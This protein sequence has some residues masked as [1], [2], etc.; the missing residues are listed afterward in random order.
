MGEVPS[1]RMMVAGVSYWPVTLKRSAMSY[2]RSGIFLAPFH[3]L[4]ENPTLALER[5]MELLQHLDALNYSE[6]WIG[7][8]HSGGFE[9]IASPELFIAAAAERTRPIRLGTGVVSLPYHN[10]FIVADRM[11]QLDY[12][13]RG[14]A[15]LGVGPGSL[16]HDAKKIGIDPAHPR[17][18]MNE[19]LDVVVSL[20]NGETVTEKSNWFD[21]HDAKL[22]L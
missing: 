17:R 13:T 11:V 22:Q 18:K 20:L 19:A 3:D 5:D 12:Q 2:L 16:V 6:A 14:R 4:A 8:H 21:L 9:I 15:M 10:P 7:E 1:G